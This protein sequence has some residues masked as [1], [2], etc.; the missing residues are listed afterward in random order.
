MTEQN[1]TRAEA[2]KSLDISANMLGRWVKEAQ[3][4]HNSFVGDIYH[5][6]GAWL[7]RSV[8]DCAN[9]GVGVPV[10]S[11]RTDQ[12]AGRHGQRCVDESAGSTD[13][14]C[15]QIHIRSRVFMNKAG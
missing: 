7:T 12:G 5:G 9:V 13:R 6:I 8:H 4:E 14:S 2:A 1:H 15:K 10:D 3:T 11:G